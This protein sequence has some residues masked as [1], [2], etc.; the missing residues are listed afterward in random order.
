M[1]VTDSA[2]CPCLD[3]RPGWNNRLFN[4][5]ILIITCLSVQKYYDAMPEC[6]I[7]L[8][9]PPTAAA[10]VVVS[11]VIISADYFTCKHCTCALYN[12]LFTAYCLYTVYWS[13]YITVLFH[14]ANK[15]IPRWEWDKKSAD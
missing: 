8:T 5:L 6:T 15:N 12:P 4:L 7:A 3:C 2:A 1:F 9:R 11:T 13:C 10:P 14:I